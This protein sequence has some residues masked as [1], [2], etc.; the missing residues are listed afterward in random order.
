MLVEEPRVEVEDAVADDV[1]AEVARLDHARV[2]RPDRDLVGVVAAHGHR[3]AVERGFVVDER[4]QRLVAVEADAV[5]VGR[6][7]LVP[8]GRRGEVDDRGHGAVLD[9]ASPGASNRPARRAACARRRRSRAGPR[10]AT[11]TRVPRP[12]ARGRAHEIPATSALTMSLPGSQMPAAVSPSKQHSRD[13]GQN[14]NAAQAGHGTANVAATRLADRR[15]QQRVHEAEEAESEQERRR[16]RGPRPAALESARDDQQ[17]AQEERRRR[18][19]REEPE[20]DAERRSELRARVTDPRHRMSRRARLVSQERCRRVEAERLRDRVRDH[21]D[22]DACECERRAEAD[23]ERDHAHVLEA[24]V[25]EQAFPG[26]R[27]PEEGD[28]H[29]ERGEPERDQHA[30]SGVDADNRRERMLAAPRNEQHRGQQRRR[31]Q[32]GHRRG[33]L[34]VCVRQPVVHRRP[35]DLRR[36]PG[37]QQ[38]VGDDRG[39]ASGA[40]RAERMPRERAETATRDPRRE[41]HDSEQRDAEA[42]RGQDQVLPAGLERARPAAETDEQ[43][44]CGRR[45]LDEQPGAAEVA[46]ERH[47]EQDGPERVQKGEVVALVRA[48]DAPSQGTRARRA[49]WRSRRGQ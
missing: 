37:E 9:G 35:A 13:G 6:L 30:L 22:G 17:L 39:V 33:R 27:P 28:G 44:G 7:A 47:C 26:E 12:R 46:G 21:V 19:P 4:P 45:R 18:Q 32:R 49:R 5:E 36:E 31:E 15:L 42:E 38:Q 24:R 8:A 14:G 23:A 20:R 1:E 43:R 48:R 29:R 3:P 11:R 40:V 10:S 16:R 25:R 2:D 41:Q 34:R